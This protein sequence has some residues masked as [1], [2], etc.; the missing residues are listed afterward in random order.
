MDK[1]MAADADRVRAVVSGEVPKHEGAGE[2]ESH[3]GH[4]GNEKPAEHHSH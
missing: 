1:M 2:A 3:T 4:P